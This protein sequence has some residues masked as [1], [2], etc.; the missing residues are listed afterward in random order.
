MGILPYN[1]ALHNIAKFYLEMREIAFN[2][3]IQVTLKIAALPIIA[4]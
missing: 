1:H 3:F 4:H 2:Y